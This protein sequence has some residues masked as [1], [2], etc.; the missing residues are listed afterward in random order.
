MLLKAPP[1]SYPLSL[2]F[3]GINILIDIDFKNIISSHQLNYYQSLSLVK[4]LSILLLVKLLAIIN[5]N[6]YTIT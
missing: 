4:L 2:I 5:F 3:A 1:I 6:I